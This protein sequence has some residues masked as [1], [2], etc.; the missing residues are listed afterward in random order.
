MD[1]LYEL[2]SLVPPVLTGLLFWFVIRAMLRADRR[3]REAVREAE[4]E[5]AAAHP[6]EDSDTRRDGR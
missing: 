4:R 3:E 2:G 6:A 5:Y 1:L